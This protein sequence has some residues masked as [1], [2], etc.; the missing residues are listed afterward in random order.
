MLLVASLDDDANGRRV[1]I[2]SPIERAIVK[3][4]LYARVRAQQNSF[5]KT[6]IHQSSKT[7][8]RKILS[9]KS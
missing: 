5:K 6:E 9:S 2:A 1:D 3:Y 4:V 8:W 7:E